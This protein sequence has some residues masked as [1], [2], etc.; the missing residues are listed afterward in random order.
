MPA[1][2]IRQLSCHLFLVFLNRELVIVLLG[3]RSA[4]RADRST[5]MCDPTDLRM[6]RSVY[7]T[8]RLVCDC[9]VYDWCVESSTVDGK[10]ASF[11]VTAARLL[12]STK[13]PMK[14]NRCCDRGC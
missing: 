10:M 9:L 3:N 2:N 1:G 14:Q 4:E 8:E 11:A 5:F 13:H 12:R 6:L 7:V